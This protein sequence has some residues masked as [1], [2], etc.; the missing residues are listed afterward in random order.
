MDPSQICPW[1][2]QGPMPPPSPFNLWWLVILTQYTAFAFLNCTIWNISNFK[3]VMTCKF[4]YA[5]FCVRLFFIL[6]PW[7]TFQVIHPVHLHL[8]KLRNTVSTQTNQIEHSH[9][10][11]L[12]AK[13]VVATW[14]RLKLLP[15]LTLSKK[16]YQVQKAQH[17][18]NYLKIRNLYS[19]ILL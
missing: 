7:F 8:H 19:V 13:G 6:N 17:P 4:G 16:Y 9:N 1:G 5:L 3:I 18:V 12:N 11:I 2:G 14:S 10:T 15:K